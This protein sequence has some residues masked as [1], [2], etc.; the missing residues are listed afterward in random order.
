[1]DHWLVLEPRLVDTTFKTKLS[2]DTKAQRLDLCLDIKF[3]GDELDRVGTTDVPTLLEAMKKVYI[4][5]R[6]RL[7]HV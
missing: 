5:S 3:F 1:M 7:R 6:W 2:L 4:P